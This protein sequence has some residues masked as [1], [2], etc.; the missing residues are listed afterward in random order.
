M[1]GTRSSFGTRYGTHLSGSPVPQPAASLA[2][3]TPATWRNLRRFTRRSRR[4]EVAYRAV[5]RDAALHVA[6]RA[7]AHLVHVVGREHPRHLLHVAVALLARD[8]RVDVPHVR[9]MG[10]LGDLEHPH[11]RHG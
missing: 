7:P 5:P 6:V 1:P 3:V 2:P 10:V 4:S 11:P 8:A 9:E